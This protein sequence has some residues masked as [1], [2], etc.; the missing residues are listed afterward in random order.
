MPETITL[1]AND[2]CDYGKCGARAYVRVFFRTGHDLLT[3]AHH[4]HDA[5]E[6]LRKVALDIVDER[7][8][9]STQRA[10]V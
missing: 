7:H 8:T 10:G 6:E 4:F 1:T 5:E 9:L 3:C 2:R